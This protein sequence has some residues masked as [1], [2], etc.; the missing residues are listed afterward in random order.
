M[1]HRIVRPNPGSLL[2]PEALLKLG[3]PFIHAAVQVI[4]LTTDGLHLLDRVPLQQIVTFPLL[5]R[6]GHTSVKFHSLLASGD[7]P[8]KGKRCAM[9]Q[10]HVKVLTLRRIQ[11]EQVVVIRARVQAE[12]C[13]SGGLLVD[14]VTRAKILSCRIADYGGLFTLSL[15]NVLARLRAHAGQDR[16][17]G[18]C[19][20]NGVG[21]AD[22][23]GLLA[24]AEARGRQRMWCAGRPGGIDLAENGTLVA[25]MA[26]QSAR[27]LREGLRIVRRADG[28]TRHVGHGQGYAG[29]RAGQ[30]LRTRTESVAIK[31]GQAMCMPTCGALYLTPSPTLQRMSECM[32]R[33]QSIPGGSVPH[34][35]KLQHQVS[36]SIAAWQWLTPGHS[37]SSVDVLERL[38]YCPAHKIDWA[39]VLPHTAGRTEAVVTEAHVTRS[40]RARRSAIVPDD[41]SVVQP[42]ADVSH[43]SS[44]APV[45]HGEL[46]RRARDILES[47][48]E[49]LSPVELAHHIFGSVSTPQSTASPWTQLVDQLLQP[50]PLFASDD[51]GRWR[52]AA[53]DARMHGLGDVEF[54]VLDV[55]TTGLAPGRHRLI[56]VGAVIVRDGEVVANFQSLINPGR[57]I[58]QFITQF[59]GISPQMVKRAPQAAQVLPRLREFIGERPIVGHNIGFDL[60]FLNYEAD[61]CNLSPAFPTSGVDTIVLARRY[62]T[63][64]RRARLDRVAAALHIP[65]RDRH[66]ALPDAHITARVFAQLLARAREEGCQTLADLFR[67]LDGTAPSQAAPP[68]ARPT[69][70]MYLNPAWRQRFPAKPGVYLMKDEAGE[71][72]YV[73]KAKSLKDRLASYYNQPLGYTRKMDGLLQCVREIETRVLGSELEALLVESRLIKEL[74]PRYNVQLRNYEHYPFIKVD[75]QHAYPRFYATRDVSADGARYFGPFR[76]GR[77]VDA[78]IELIQKIFPVRT[79]TRSLP[80]AAAASD[81]CLRY[82]LKRCP[83]PCRGELNADTRAAYQAAVE[84]ACAFLGGDRADLVDRLKRQMFEAAAR[85]DFERAAHLRDALRDADQVLLGQRLVTGAVEANNLLIIYPSAEADHTELFLIRHGRLA[86]QM[87]VRRSAEALDGAVR[88]LVTD[89]AALGMPPARVGRAEV[90]QINI[91]ARWIHH[92][93]DDDE[94]AFFRLPRDLSNVDETNE[95]IERVVAAVMALA[96]PA[97]ELHDALG[98]VA[99]AIAA[100]S[101]TTDELPDGNGPLYP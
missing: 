98:S 20:V 3:D 4:H 82:H 81:P 14:R 13:P 61:V 10:R 86:H 31:D 56:E 32:V 8:Q 29:E 23:N 47:R 60:N 11:P 84:E 96:Q 91:I 2:R 65:V 63:G 54:V 27:E 18:L 50:S 30:H 57:R 17:C 26:P 39:Q 64:M 9:T 70:S 58:P 42:A 90:D 76:S 49:P 74:Q 36:P 25:R 24:C 93:S 71:V 19:E 94:R 5:P 41:D 45:G 15:A 37:P 22:L 87:R 80:P 97:S 78:T 38:C 52:L 34:L 68:V 55:E 69:G 1:I 66:R 62:L 46:L 43:S 21:F 33:N 99:P 16:L 6:I 83:G 12:A 85:Q 67:V 53:W 44:A 100:E 73:G 95:F 89:A 35:A 40:A 77:I 101:E 72:I 79:C 88:E 7:Y 59:T 28:S 48:G 75:V 51:A 92:H